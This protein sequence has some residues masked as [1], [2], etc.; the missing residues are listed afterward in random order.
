MTS[1][2]H[3][4]SDEGTGPSIHASAIGDALAHGRTNDNEPGVDAATAFP[5]GQSERG[6]DAHPA[7]AED[8]TDAEAALLQLFLEHRGQILG[9]DALSAQLAE[10]AG[11]SPSPGEPPSPDVV[12]RLVDALAAKLALDPDRWQIRGV[13]GQGYT[14]WR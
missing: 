11:S 10:V 3:G 8:F 6:G 13:E 4:S 7:S 14:L 1:I 2:P 5:R 9:L 12:A